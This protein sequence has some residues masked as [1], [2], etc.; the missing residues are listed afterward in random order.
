[1]LR[2]V[3]GYISLDT[4]GTGVT[5]ALIPVVM[6]IVDVRLPAAWGSLMLAKVYKDLYQIVYQGG[7]R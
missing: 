3:L 5:L 1:M 7:S 2:L 4:G 6:G